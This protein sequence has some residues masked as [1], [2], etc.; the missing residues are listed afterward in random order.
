MDEKINFESLSEYLKN[1]YPGR[2]YLLDCDID[3]QCGILQIFLDELNFRNFR[4]IDEVHKALERTQKA[5]EL[6]EIEFPPEEKEGRQYSP[7]CIARISMRLLD[8][9][10]FPYRKIFPFDDIPPEMLEKYRKHILPE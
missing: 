8:S 5:V 6:F 10:F 3:K 2:E 9:N 1:R 7:T 4:K